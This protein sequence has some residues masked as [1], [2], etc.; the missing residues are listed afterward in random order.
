[1]KQYR[2]I[3]ASKRINRLIIPFKRMNVTI[4]IFYCFWGQ[5]KNTTILEELFGCQ[6]FSGSNNFF[7]FFLRTDLG[8]GIILKQYRLIKG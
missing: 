7:K 2:F 5:P 8:A 3:I 4:S 1:M 6:N